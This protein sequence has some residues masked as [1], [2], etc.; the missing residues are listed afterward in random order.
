MSHS[1]ERRRPSGTWEQ[2]AKNLTE[3]GAASGDG[4]GLEQSCEW[5]LG[6]KKGMDLLKKSQAPRGVGSSG[7]KCNASYSMAW[8]E[9]SELASMGGLRGKYR[10][11]K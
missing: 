1:N 6:E 9:Q 11:G 10:V 4:I 2:G 3:K 8:G 5:D 7:K